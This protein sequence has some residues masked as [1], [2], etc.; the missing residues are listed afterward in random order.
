MYLW[1]ENPVC[2]MVSLLAYDEYFPAE[3]GPSVVLLHGFGETRAIW[4]DFAPALAQRFRVLSLDLPGFGGSRDFLPNPCTIEALAARVLALLDHLHLSQYLL[5]GHSLGG[6]VALALAEAR[7]QAVL[8]LSLFHSTARPA[9]LKKKKSRE[10]VLTF[11]DKNGLAPF[12]DNFVPPLFYEAR[13]AEL[14]QAIQTVKILALSTP[15]TTFTEVMQAMRDRPDRSHVLAQANF[16]IQFVIGRQDT[17]VPFESY[18]DQIILPKNADIQVLD[19]TGHMG[20]YERPRRTLRMLQ[21]FLKN[22]ADILP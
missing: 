4:K 5:V 1:E 12:I 17:S 19:Q 2:S 13:Q 9:V 22:S 10:N 14:H 6:Y 3:A 8:G 21:N 11:I 15:K 20:Q 18:A 16:P 7:P